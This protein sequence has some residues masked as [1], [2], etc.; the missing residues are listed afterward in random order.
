MFDLDETLIHC[1]D[2]IDKPS[3]VILPIV[4]D[5]GDVI[6]VIILTFSIYFHISNNIKN[7]NH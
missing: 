3:D 7:F 5:T 1:N 4:F 6:Q 2:T